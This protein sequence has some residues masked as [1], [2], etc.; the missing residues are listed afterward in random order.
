MKGEKRVGEK[1]QLSWETE[2][3]LL[4]KAI[5]A[6]D[7]FYLRHHAVLRRANS[8]NAVRKGSCG[9]ETGEIA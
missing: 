1:I 9:D 7:E 4:G 2:S 6:A 8:P 5:T 3:A